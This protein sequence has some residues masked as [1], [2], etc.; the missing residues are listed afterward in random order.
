MTEAYKKTPPPPENP[1][2]P[3]DTD[4]SAINKEN[5]GTESRLNPPEIKEVKF[6]SDPKTVKKKTQGGIL[7]FQTIFTLLFCLFYTLTRYLAP[8]LQQNISAYLERLFGW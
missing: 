6:F 8:E 2:I 5:I 1:P 3:P 7:A 4:A